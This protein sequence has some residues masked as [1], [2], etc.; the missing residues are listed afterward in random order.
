MAAGIPIEKAQQYLEEFGALLVEHKK[1]DPFTE[2]RVR[3][4]LSVAPTHT[5]NIVLSYLDAITGKVESGLPYLRSC[6]DVNVNDVNLAMH[7][8]QILFNTFSY[9]EINRVSYSLADKYLTKRFSHA[10]YS[11]AYRY[12]DREK[13]VHYMD[14][15]IKLLSESE[16]RSNAMQH[17]D[18]LLAEMDNFY[19]ATQCSPEQFKALASIIWTLLSDHKVTTGFVQLSSSGCYVVDITDSEPKAIAKMNFELAEKVCSEPMLDD[20]ALLARFTSPR[21]L[22]TGVSYRVGNK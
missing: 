11:C 9:N 10:A 2:K 3:A 7:Y 18:E 16:G 1:L 12:G 22:H 21:Q 17:K 5:T 20:C 15:H 4:E 6:L 13:L 8:Y 19:D 14:M